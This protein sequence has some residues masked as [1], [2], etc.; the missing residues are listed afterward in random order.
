MIHRFFKPL[1]QLLLFLDRRILILTFAYVSLIFIVSLSYWKRYQWN[2]SS[3]VNFGREFVLQNEEETPKNSIVFLGEEGDLGAGY[4]GQI[5]Y[6]FSRSLTNVSFE[7]PKGFDES[8][9]APRIGYPFLISLFG[10]LGKWGSIFGMYFWNLFLW[11]LSF[12]ALRKLLPED[13]RHYSIFYL[14]NPFALGSYYVLVSDSVMVSLVILA[15]Y[16][17]LNHKPLAFVLLSSLAILTKEPALFF[18]FPLGL[19]VLINRE[20]KK[21]FLVGSTLLIP[22]LWHSYLSYRFPNWRASRLTDFILP[23]EG[24]ISYTETIF[25]SMNQ[26]VIQWKEIARLFSRF[27]LVLLFFLGTISAFTGKL[28]KGWEFRIGLLFTMF[29]VATAG[30][31]H[32]WSVYEN[33]SRMFTISVP[34][35][36]FLIA[37][38][39]EVK[40]KEYFILLAIVLFLFLLKAIFISKTLSYQIWN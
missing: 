3:M 30:Y 29:M 17:F 14:F 12:F 5:F 31:Y 27:P 25:Y 33:V 38:D 24:M 11:I 13:L 37:R 23:F 39:R 9:R 1:N 7:W 34:I 26:S 22:I 15:Y 32:F 18:L 2:P 4:D 6:F 20:W 36:L 28:K 40:Y 16:C 21:V 8:Y 10:F 35:F 19:S